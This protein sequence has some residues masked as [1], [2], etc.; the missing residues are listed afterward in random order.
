[1]KLQRGRD[2]RIFR[3]VFFEHLNYEDLIDEQ[4]ST[5][6]KHVG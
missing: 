3:Q 1:M 4:F 5:L 6:F 2:N